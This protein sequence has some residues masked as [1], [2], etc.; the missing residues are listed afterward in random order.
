MFYS[1]GVHHGR[2]YRQVR[3][4]F[5]V[6]F[7]RPPPGGCVL[8]LA[9]GLCR[10]L[11]DV[12]S[13]MCIVRAITLA[14]NLGGVGWSHKAPLSRWDP[15]SVEGDLRVPSPRALCRKDSAMELCPSR[16]KGLLL[17]LGHMKYV[18]STSV[19]PHS[20]RSISLLPLFGTLCIRAPKEEII[21]RS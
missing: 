21:K 11:I 3:C 13:P 19:P 17:T 7:L 9:T 2:S 10:G 20:A 4:R 5:R 12:H 16:G 8:F 15:L 1:D 14:L 6:S 18:Q